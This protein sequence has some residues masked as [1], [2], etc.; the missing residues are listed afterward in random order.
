MRVLLGR[1][2][3]MRAR[4][5]GRIESGISI[6]IS[7]AVQRLFLSAGVS[8]VNGGSTFLSESTR[9]PETSQ[10][11]GCLVVRHARHCQG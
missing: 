6:V 1:F 3:L 9:H 4:L 10:A 8:S 11:L 5:P 7:H 2:R